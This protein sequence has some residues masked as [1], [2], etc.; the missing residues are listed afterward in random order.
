MSRVEDV[1]PTS[2]Q[3]VARSFHPGMG[4]GG[5]LREE[6]RAQPDAGDCDNESKTTAAATVAATAKTNVHGDHE[7][8]RRVICRCF[9]F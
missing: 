5:A 8:V 6:R 3:L 1:V 7:S 4:I 9:W 2:P